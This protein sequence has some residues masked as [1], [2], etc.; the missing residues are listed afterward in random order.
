MWYQNSSIADIVADKQT[1]KSIK[2][3]EVAYL[4]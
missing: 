2:T 3:Q 4:P 1:K